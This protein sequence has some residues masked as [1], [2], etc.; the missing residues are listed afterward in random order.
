[1]TPPAG[2]FTNDAARRAF[3]L[4][5]REIIQLIPGEAWANTAGKIEQHDLARLL[6][7]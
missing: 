6:A 4:V 5:F 2:R 3:A 1:L 7:A